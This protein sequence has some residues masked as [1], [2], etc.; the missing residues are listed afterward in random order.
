MIKIQ[1]YLRND[2]DSKIDEIEITKEELLQLACNKAKERY[3][4]GHW[5]GIHADDE[6][7]IENIKL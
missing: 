5:N 4:E 3:M 7:K 2:F 6:I 1:V